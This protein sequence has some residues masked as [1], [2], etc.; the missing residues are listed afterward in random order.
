MF[1][2]RL[3]EIVHRADSP[4]LYAGSFPTRFSRTLDGWG[5]FANVNDGGIEKGL[6]TL[7]EETAR[8]RQYGFLAS[9]LARAK[10]EMRAGDESAWA[11]RDKSESP[12]FAEAYVGGFLNDVP[13]PG[14]A[15]RHTLT[16][17]LLGGI[18]LEEVNALSAHLMPEDGRVVL[19]SA[20]EKPGVAVPSEAALRALVARGAQGALAA[21][22]DDVAGSA[23][24]TTLPTPGRVVSRR[25][26]EEIGVTVLTL[27]NGVDVWLK[28]TD[29]K[30]DEIVFGAEAQGGASLADS[31]AYLAAGLAPVIVGRSGVGG[32][33]ATDLQKLLAGRI[34]SAGTYIRDY[35]QGLSG[36][37]RPADLETALQLAYLNFTRLT[38]DSA[39]FLAL[40][41]SFHGMLVERGNSPE[42]AF[43]DTLRAVN[44]GGFYMDR[45]PT[46]AEMDSV[47][48]EDALAFHRRTFANAADFTFF[49]VG[50]FQ[51]DSVV[52]LLERYVASLP[53]TGR[54]TS[55]YVAIGPR[56]PHAVR[57]VVVRRGVEPKGSTQI[58]FFVNDGLEEL[59]L[60][61]ARTCASILTEHLRQSLREMLG[62]TYSA[63]ASFAYI[64]PLPGYATMT[65]EF[66]CD[67][68]RVDSLVAAA[69]VEVRKLRDEGPSDADLQ[70]E[71]EIQHRELETSLKENGYWLGGLEVMNR[72]GFD[73]RRIAKRG[74]RIDRL[75][76]A[77]LKTTFA[78]YFPLDRYTVV[79]LLPAAAAAKGR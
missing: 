68:G 23:L 11:E 28:P 40:Q 9:E 31:A 67:P 62:G 50:S 1:N 4:F 79:T 15:T 66:G 32:F 42:A 35:T 65:I 76:A 56:Y 7:L 33:T 39:S 16:Q 10:E 43:Q 54:R 34:A 77:D 45:M 55:S 70:R 78:K 48:L 49:M 17:A 75:T 44:T 52:P 46:A 61:R 2:A 5:V 63:T 26:I 3:N 36:S 29:F 57:R 74:E 73:P 60:H 25:A 13:A 41:R 12:G 38:T 71:K 22:K 14:I 30:A 47:R 24:M 69:L 21:W 20:P 27:S 53:S 51:V 37:A 59:D 58:T 6:T 19:A 18:T 72:L 8:V 64:T